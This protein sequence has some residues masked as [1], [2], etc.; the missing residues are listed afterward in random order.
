[1]ARLLSGIDC[2]YTSSCPYVEDI[3]RIRID[4]GEVKLIVQRKEIDM[5][6]DIKSVYR[7]I[8]LYG[9]FTAGKVG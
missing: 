4:W 9:H 8:S 5:V 3:L 1:M 2:P 6:Y 7:L